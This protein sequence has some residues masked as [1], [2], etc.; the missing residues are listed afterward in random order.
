MSWFDD[1]F[2]HLVDVQKLDDA[3]DYGDEVWLAKVVDVPA[4]VEAHSEVIRNVEGE[5][6][7][8]RYK[9]AIGYAL[10]HQDRVWVDDVM[11]RVVAHK[12]AS[13][14]GD[15]MHEVKLS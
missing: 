8:T 14:D 15:V 1:Q 4:Q 2:E 9:V 10:A 7:T 5:E 12:S 6:I 11:Y 3:N 13:M